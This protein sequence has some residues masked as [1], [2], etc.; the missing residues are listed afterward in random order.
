MDDPTTDDTVFGRLVW[1]GFQH[2]GWAGS[3]ADEEFL[4]WGRAVSEAFPD[5]E[6]EDADEH[7]QEKRPKTSSQDFLNELL[8]AA[9][10][11][12]QALA[13]DPEALK[14]LQMS[15]AFA[16][17][18]D[19]YD[20]KLDA[21][22]LRKSGRLKVVVRN[23]KST[24][25]T[26]AQQA[27]WKA[28]RDRGD[29]LA[30]E[31]AKALLMTYK[32]QRPERVRWFDAI[33][34]G[35]PSVTYPDVR[36]SRKMRTIVRPSEFRVYPADMHGVAVAVVCENFWSDRDVKV[37]VCDGRV[38]AVEPLEHD[39]VA[40]DGKAVETVDAPVFGRVTR[41]EYSDNWV[42]VYKPELIHG[43]HEASQTRY[44]YKKSPENYTM[45]PWRS[46]PG[47]DVITGEY[48]LTISA[49]KAQRP[50]AEQA[51]AYQRFVADQSVTENAV[52]QALFDWYKGIRPDWVKQM[53]GSKAE[54]A[55]TLP[56]VKKSTDLLE[57]IQLEGVHVLSAPTPEETAGPRT[58]EP[59]AFLK[60]KDKKR[61]KTFTLPPKKP[62]IAIVIGFHWEDE[63]GLAARWRDGVVEKIGSFDDIYDD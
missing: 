10:V 5:D 42:G 59:P 60:A 43:Y 17:R 23:D 32:K 18:V 49:E 12:G 45:S 8:T 11:E 51:A 14:I 13:K 4:S 31:I 57:F 24:P 53:N 58:I 27:A 9:G 30:E 1:D 44:R 28:F 7:E 20:G 46:G 61:F 22:P 26:A 48:R 36:T 35:D 6:D 54:I 34:G 55:A 3:F 63:H 15:M 29:A 47:W 33:Y 62:G 40:T 37:V 2:H 50:T 41:H 19:A 21:G 16:Q 52:L 56:A 25:P 38:A 39:G